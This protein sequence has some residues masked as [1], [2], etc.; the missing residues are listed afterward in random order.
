M[1]EKKRVEGD[2]M[3]ID[4]FTTCIKMDIKKEL[5]S[6]YT[7]EVKDITKNNDTRLKG[8][9]IMEQG[10]SMH[11]TI[12]MESFY[13]QYKAGGTLE[14]IKDSILQ[15]FQESGAGKQFDVAFFA[16]WKKVKE[17][18]TYKLINFERNWELLKD[19]PHKKFLDLAIVYECFLGIGNAGGVVILIHDSHIKSWGVTVDELHAAAL[20]NTPELMGYSLASMTEVM[21]EIMGSGK[22]ELDG[23]EELQSREELE[24][25]IFPMYVLTNHHKLHGAG[26]ILYK[27]L[28]Q[29]IAEKWKCNLII[30]PS[31]IHEVILIPMN[32][33]GNYVEMAQIVREVNQTQ[34]MPEEVLSDHVY[35]FSSETGK[36][37]MQEEEEYE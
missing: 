20:Q 11:P 22:A 16:D 10:S 31:S 3:S 28:L 23:I 12:Y 30:L 14:E 7:L 34:V 37:I 19:V 1:Q 27:N 6:R 29:E 13:E 9:I 5:G 35:Q 4:G 33:A 21:Q 24:K 15:T 36:I 8:L 25:D 32:K 17:R 18:V 2:L 26:C